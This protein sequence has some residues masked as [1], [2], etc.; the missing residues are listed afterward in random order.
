MSK[1]PRARG[2]VPEFLLEVGCEELPA[3]WLEGLGEQLRQRFADTA[4]RERLG[5]QDARVW[6]TPRR[7]ALAADVIARQE[8][9]DETV[10]GPSL[11]VARK[12]G[13][14]TQ[15]ALGFA[16]KGGLEAD[17]LQQGAKDAGS[18][19]QYLFFVRRTPG[20][21]AREVLPAVIAQVLRGLA[22][23]KRMSWD[24]WLEDGKGLFPFGRPI[25][26]MVALLG[27]EVVPF[28]VYTA[29]AGARGEPLVPTGAETRGHRFLPRGQGGTPV[30][31]AGGADLQQKLRERFVLLDPQERA[32][33]IAEGLRR[34]NGGRDVA[35]D[36]GLP[37][38]WR[39]LVEYPTVVA[40]RIPG[41]FQSLPVEVLQTVLI[42]HQ[43][44][45][46]LVAGGAVERFAAVV[47]GDAEN[48][49]EIVRGME[50][51]VV[52]RLRDAAFFFAEDRKRPLADRVPD[53]AGVTLHQ[54][55][56][57]YLDKAERMVRLVD[58][59]GGELKVLARPEH[60]AARQAARLAKADLTT[61]IVREFPELQGTMGGLYLGAEGT[62]A[63]AVRAAVRW[64]YHPVAVEE[65][66]APHGQL[67]GSDA[68]VFAAVSLADK[69]DTLA[70]YF[71]LGEA[72]TGSRDPFGLRRAGQGAVRLLLDFW[73]PAAGHGRPSLQRL[74]SL[75][76][77]GYE[78]K[79]KRP[80]AEVERDL[81]AFLLD[82]LEYV[83]ATRFPR[84]E[85]EA[86]L[87]TPGADPL[88]DPFDSLVRVRALHGVR[89]E[90]NE[91]F[92]HL[93]VAFKRAKNI[94]HGQ[95]PPPEVEPSLFQSPAERDLHEAVGRLLASNGGSRDG[96]YD[97]RLRSLAALRGPVDRFFDDVLVMAEE[98]QL[99]ANRLSL[100]QQT[101][102][103]FYRIADISKLGGSA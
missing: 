47:N 92:A 22:F 95:P 77:H 15:A 38:E 93:A 37:A 20:R 3:P 70:G 27:G 54:G 21:D 52:A 16:R 28:T 30:R 87:A 51:V 5:G 13:A 49:A 84:E 57:S 60:D 79:L 33:R 41:E 44:Y 76:I 26:W 100:L 94:L 17:A 6:W 23:P 36:H 71:G 4:Q 90:A 43:K 19:E 64:H 101:L 88:D 24:A 97:A 74:T 62:H 63:P 2:S 11:K 66:A 34:E 56:G 85:V 42:H 82:R 103:L 61:L 89:G 12:D 9:R 48:A 69:L 45:V 72:P 39:D 86:V 55:L 31:V 18:P 50:R 80:P 65:G 68:T 58:A 40:G 7:L 73:H 53:L 29:V 8:D 1:A 35:D 83:L 59:M 32:A 25:R 75:A 102:S 96:G 46:P 91:D 10:W 14:W 81:L 78:G 98:P 99:R 67:T